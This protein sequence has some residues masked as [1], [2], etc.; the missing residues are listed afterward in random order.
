VAL[1][2]AETVEPIA[3]PV[4]PEVEVS[5]KDEPTLPDRA[6]PLVA[7]L[8]PAEG[9]ILTKREVVVRGSVSD[10]SPPETVTVEGVEVPLRADGGFEARLS[11][12]GVEGRVS[13]AALARDAAGNE[14]R[15]AA[16]VVLDLSPPA[17]ELSAPARSRSTGGGRTSPT[18]GPSRPSFRSSSLARGAWPSRPGIRP[19]SAFA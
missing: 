19:V 1:E 4:E 9:T 14:G 8:E 17:L 10:A 12:K 18:R 3:K 13:L 15:A 11:L 6:P 2:V 7:I 5:P 16:A